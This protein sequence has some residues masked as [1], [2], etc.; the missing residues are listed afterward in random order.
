[1]SDSK[2]FTQLRS[3]VIVLLVGFLI[4]FIPMWLRTR[5]RTSERDAALH[6]LQMSGLK[7]Q[8]SEAALES[9]RGHYET[10]RQNVSGF[11]TSLNNAME[12]ST[13]TDLTP[14]QLKSLQPVFSERDELIT[15]LAR[16][17]P[18][19]ADR[20]LNLDLAFRKILGHP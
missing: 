17:D 5:H 15:L 14:E 11:F 13:G 3:L 7:A 18:A 1:M 10:A 20:L 12:H 4:G 8:L 19:S 9:R 16:N 6:Q 2:R